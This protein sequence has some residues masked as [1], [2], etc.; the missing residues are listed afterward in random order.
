MDLTDKK[1]IEDIAKEIRQN[2]NGRLLIDEPLS[3]HTSFR[4]GGPARFYFYPSR[5]K[6][7]TNIIE[8]CKDKRL[9]SFIIGFGTN[10]LV[11]DRGFAGCVI[12]LAE[13]CRGIEIE[14]VQ[15]TAGA[16]VC[17]NDVV[18]TA[19]ENG[20]DGLTRHAGVPGAIGGWVFMNSGAF[21]SSISDYLID[22]KVLGQDGTVLTMTKDDIGFTYR[23]APGLNGKIILNAR[24]GLKRG[25][26]YQL[27]HEVEEI[28]KERYRRHVMI[29]PS[30]GSV[31]KNPPGRFAA[32][33]ID[34]VGGKGMAV[35]GVAVSS[36]HANIIVNRNGTASDV[37][38]LI[39]RIRKMIKERYEVDLELEIKTLG[40]EDDAPQKV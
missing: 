31:F 26:R 5:V 1:S 6:D 4:I 18:R 16:G 17:G 14:D 35:G 10:L 27:L 19:A 28:I 23:A 29:L 13:A 30:T 7:L 34:S 21:R 40:F 22:V 36:Q 2:I 9:K 33:L 38:E 3:G 12:D 39:G 11:S 15:L 20:L 32:K 24:F 25:N 37:V 8:Y